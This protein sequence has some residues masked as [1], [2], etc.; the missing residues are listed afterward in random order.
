[1]STLENISSNS[2]QVSI[3]EASTAADIQKQ[4][5][6]SHH[7]VTVVNPSGENQALLTDDKE[8]CKCISEIQS[9]C[10]CAFSALGAI[11]CAIG[12]GTSRNSLS[13]GAQI[14][15]LV[16]TGVFGVMALVTFVIHFYKSECYHPPGY[17]YSALGY[18]RGAAHPCGG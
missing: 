7:T 3:G 10:C 5:T 16:F 12:Y 6:L 9:L 4:G 18:N 1:M 15:L 8:P 17:H 14:S 11:G 13:Q 2:I